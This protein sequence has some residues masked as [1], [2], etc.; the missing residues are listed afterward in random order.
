M[1]SI[2][3]NRCWV[4]V[5]LS[6]C[7]LSVN[8]ILRHMVYIYF[9]IFCISVIDVSIIFISVLSDISHTNMKC[10]VNFVIH[11]FIIAVVIKY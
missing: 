5:S 6:L 9:A 10:F 11:I 4:S 8:L 3:I 2:Y 7:N 1:L